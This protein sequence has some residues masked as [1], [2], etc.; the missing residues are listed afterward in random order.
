MSGVGVSR[1]GSDQVV[2]VPGRIVALGVLV[3][4]ALVVSAVLLGR[5]S[6]SV[7]IT[8]ESRSGRPAPAV[9]GPASAGAGG[10]TGS[11]GP[12]SRGDGV[13][14]GGGL[15]GGSPLGSGGAICLLA[16]PC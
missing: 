5:W 9:S 2:V 13:V 7:S 6:A 11:A 10:A 4:L 3:V 1:G 12:L 14:T 16:R 15:L 8:Q